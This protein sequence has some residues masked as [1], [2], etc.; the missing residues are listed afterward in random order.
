[1]RDTSDKVII[2]DGRSDPA[3]HSFQEFRLAARSEPD[4]AT[5]ETSLGR[6]LVI[7]TVNI[8][9]VSLKKEVLLPKTCWLLAVVRDGS[10]PRFLTTRCSPRTVKFGATLSLLRPVGCLLSSKKVL[11]PLSPVTHCLPRTVKCS[12]SF[13]DF[14]ELSSVHFS[15]RM[16]WC[17]FCQ[18]AVRPAPSR[19]VALACNCQVSQGDASQEF[20]VST[21]HWMF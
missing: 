13:F 11:L 8:A 18:P 9:R 1:M 14:K 21:A 15:K 6:G 7:L 16:F 19:F 2:Q 5:R 10:G 17:R 12:S 3:A 4:E 20:V